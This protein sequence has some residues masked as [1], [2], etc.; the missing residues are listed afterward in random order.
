MKSVVTI[1]LKLSYNKILLETMRQYSYSANRVIDFGWDIKTDNKIEL[2]NLTYYKIRNET[3]L[4]AQLVCSSRDKAVEVLKSV[5][6]Q[7][8]SKPI[9]KEFLTIRYNDRS[10]KLRCNKED[11]FVSLSTIKGRIKIPVEIPEYYW[12]YLDWK[13]C[14]ANLFLDEKR[15]LFLNINFSKDIKT[16]DDNSNIVGIDMGINNLAVTS[17]K[18]FFNSG[19]IKYKKIHFK[20]L[21]AKL[22]AKG[23]R[24]AKKLLKKISSR[25]KRFMVWINHNISKQIVDK[26]GR[27]I[28]VMENLR[29]IRNRKVGKKQRFWL[30][31]WGFYQLQNFIEYKANMRGMKVVKVCPENTSK[32]CSRCNALN[33]RFKSFFKCKSCGYSLNAD[34]NASFNL[35]KHSTICEN[36]LVAVNQPDITNNDA[37]ASF[38]GFSRV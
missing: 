9:M 35:A 25:E 26:I 24:S 14:S 15:R 1:K 20:H 6:K 21:K 37:E 31:S 29:G 7:R 28:I 16:F 5:F 23:T 27:G 17:Q 13:I 22:Q 30:H 34:L 11:Y 8:G 3:Q 33:R 36:V 19:K 12:K 38:D 32:A 18:Q 4:P 10:F 2:H